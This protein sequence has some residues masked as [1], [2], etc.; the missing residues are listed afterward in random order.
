MGG[1]KKRAEQAAK[2]AK[3]R[4]EK[5]LKLQAENDNK[6]KAKEKQKKAKKAEKKAKH[7]KVNKKDV[8]TVE[9]WCTKTIK[10][11]GS[12]DGTLAAGSKSVRKMASFAKK[13]CAREKRAAAKA[14]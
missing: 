13:A 4:K 6:Q 14:A 2:K 10:V 11:A 1:K 9:K 7:E 5:G 3:A 8:A 12:L